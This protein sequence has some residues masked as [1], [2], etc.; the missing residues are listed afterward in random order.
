MFRASFIP[1]RRRSIRDDYCKFEFEVKKGNPN[2]ICEDFVYSIPT[3][4]NTLE[5]QLKLTTGI[6][7]KLNLVGNEFPEISPRAIKNSFLE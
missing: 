7:G 5:R 1:F 6:I 3:K 2:K 4:L